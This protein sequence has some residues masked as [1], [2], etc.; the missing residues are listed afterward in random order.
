LGVVEHTQAAEARS[1]LCFCFSFLRGK[2]TDERTNLGKS[3]RSNEYESYLW[4]GRL[5]AFLLLFSPKE[6]LCHFPFFLFLSPGSG[7]CFSFA[8]LGSGLEAPY[9]VVGPSCCSDVDGSRFGGIP[10]TPLCCAMLYLFT[11]ISLSCLRSFNKGRASNIR[12]VLYKSA[13]LNPSSFENRCVEVLLIDVVDVRSRRLTSSYPNP[14]TDERFI[15][16]RRQNRTSDR[17]A[18]RRPGALF[19][20]FLF[21]FVDWQSIWREWWFLPCETGIRHAF[22]LFLKPGMREPLRYRVQR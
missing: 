19:V 18:S 14:N 16:S 7:E 13:H 9:A 1:V 5:V 15:L 6:F 2:R 20:M 17:H 4:L 21:V 10:I 8:L 11:M 3:N 12:P 22:S